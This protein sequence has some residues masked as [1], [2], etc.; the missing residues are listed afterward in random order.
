MRRR[1]R[2]KLRRGEF[3]ELGFHVYALHADEDAGCPCC[4]GWL[5][6]FVKWLWRTR[7]LS[8]GGGGGNKATGLYV[9]SSKRGSATEADRVAA[10]AWLADRSEVAAHAVGPLSDAWHTSEAR[11]ELVTRLLETSAAAGGRLL[12]PLDLNR[13]Y[14]EARPAPAATPR[15]EA[16]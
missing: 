16:M 4:G 11:L 14:A 1:L 3:T 12:E 9:A 10:S 7:G 15:R 13:A 2:K 5:D 6:E 8:C